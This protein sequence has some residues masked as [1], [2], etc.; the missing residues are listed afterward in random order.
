LMRMS[1]GLVCAPAHFL[2]TVASERSITRD[3]V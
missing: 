2:S 3:L 1:A